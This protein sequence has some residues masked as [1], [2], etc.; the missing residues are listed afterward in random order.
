MP[1]D[2]KDVVAAGAAGNSGVPPSSPARRHS[3][4]TD[5]TTLFWQLMYAALLAVVSVASAWR[6]LDTM[7]GGRSPWH[8][9]WYGWVTALSTGL[10]ALPMLM[11]KRVSD[12]YLGMA[13]ALAAGMMTAASAAL[14]AEGMEVEMVQEGSFA[15]GQS[16]IFGVAVGV[17]FIVVSQHALKEHSDVQ[18]GILD[19]VNA[20]KV[21]HAMPASAT[22]ARHRLRR[23]Q[24]LLI[25]IVMTVHSFSE[26]IGIGV[27]FGAA[28]A[29]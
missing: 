10:G 25:V 2:E 3:V 27:S 19:R 28:S 26:G 22:R 4:C 24:A 16:V 21:A 23:A 6:V 1:G 15:P 9:W 11:C 14:V 5:R 12:W 20:R 29:P 7:Y 8:V 13:N 18:L 17:A